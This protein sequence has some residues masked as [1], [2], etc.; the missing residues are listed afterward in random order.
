VY[1]PNKSESTTVYVSCFD[2]FTSLTCYIQTVLVSYLYC[3]SLCTYVR[4]TFHY[5]TVSE[6]QNSS[7]TLR[8]CFFSW[9]L[10]ASFIYSA[11]ILEEFHLIHL[12]LSPTY[13]VIYRLY[14][15]YN[16]KTYIKL[17]LLLNISCLASLMHIAL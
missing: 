8:F 12:D 15:Q 4:S 10:L 6:L 7:Q 1:F 11:R 14:R 9:Q 13:I 17:L 2:Y 3:G 16:C 5:R